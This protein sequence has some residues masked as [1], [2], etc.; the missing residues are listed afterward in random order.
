MKEVTR[1]INIARTAEEVFE[2]TTNPANT[3]KWIAFIAEEQTNLWPPKVG[4]IYRN[5]SGNGPWS[6]YEVTSYSKNQ[7]FTLSRK[8]SSLRVTYIIKPIGDNMTELEYH[9]RVD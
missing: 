8:N 9:E 2:F 7:E 3:P 5:H 4:T 6:E 1:R